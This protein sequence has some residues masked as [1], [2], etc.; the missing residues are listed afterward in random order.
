MSNIAAVHRDD[1][2]PWSIVP[3]RDV[4]TWRCLRCGALR[5]KPH[6]HTVGL[7][8]VRYQMPGKMPVSKMPECQ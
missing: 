5:F 7:T 2:H 8:G 1:S 3:G 4:E 6:V